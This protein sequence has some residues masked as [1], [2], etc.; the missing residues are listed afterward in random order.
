MRAGALVIVLGLVLVVL[1]G[2]TS[3]QGSQ[4][5]LDSPV[6]AACA[7]QGEGCHQPTLDGSRQFVINHRVLAGGCPGADLHVMEYIQES[8]GRSAPMVAS[9]CS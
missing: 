5:K 4:T 7:V 2:Q 3:L 9:W 1:A 6:V 8:E